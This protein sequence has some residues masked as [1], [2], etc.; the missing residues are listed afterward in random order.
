[1]RE[2]SYGRERGHDQHHARRS[3]DA[4]V[5]TVGKRTLTMDLYPTHTHAGADAIA[6]TPVTARTA[7]ARDGGTPAP[8]G[9]HPPSPTSTN[10]IERL[11]G[12]PA[13]GASPEREAG[14][15]APGP[16]VPVNQTG[17]PDALKRGIEALS[18]FS[19]DDVRV[20]YNSSLPDEHDAHAHTHGT[21]IYIA[22]GQ[23]SYLGHEAWHVVQQLQGRVRSSPDADG[24]NLN[25]DPALEQEADQMAARALSVAAPPAVPLQRPAL[26]RPVTQLGKRTKEVTVDVPGVKQRSSNLCWAA[27]GYSIY[28][29]FGINKTKYKKLNS[30]V[31]AL[32]GPAIKLTKKKEPP[33]KVQDIDDIIGTGSQENLLVGSNSTAPFGKNGIT[34]Q[35]TSGKPIVANVDGQHYVIICGRRNNGR[36]FEVQLMDPLTGK[37]TWVKTHGQKSSIAKVGSYTLTTLYYLK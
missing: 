28:K 8:D 22:S 32:H 6:D 11:F 26:T 27:V 15:Q 21:N 1:V 20:H 2:L 17:L 18:G 29:R 7:P 34:M 10:R 5:P 35:L 12:T 23:E 14:P 4:P 19:L 16:Q 9:A 25:D 13:S 24:E 31:K 33:N 36:K 37:K 3:T 30:F